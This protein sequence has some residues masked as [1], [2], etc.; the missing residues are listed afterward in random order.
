[1]TTPADESRAGLS[2][3]KAALSILTQV[4]R[5]RRPLDTQLDLLKALPPRD[6]GFARALA[7]ETLRHFGELD[8]LIEAFERAR[9][10]DAVLIAGRGDRVTRRPS[11]KGSA[12]DDREVAL[13]WLYGQTEP[14]QSR[15]R[16]RVVG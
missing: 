6:A 7:S 15:P 8:A 16:F 14:T 12:Y 2:A 1:M 13:E 9:P 4:L 11:G 10:G 5:Q 3:R